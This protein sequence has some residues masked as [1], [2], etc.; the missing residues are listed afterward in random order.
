MREKREGFREE[1]R[2]TGRPTEHFL[3]SN[4]QP[5]ARAGRDSEAGYREDAGGEH[6]GE[7]HSHQSQLRESFSLYVS[8]GETRKDYSL[9]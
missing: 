5:Q 4:H 8:P 9:E 2:G 7:V 6:K 1:G 3:G